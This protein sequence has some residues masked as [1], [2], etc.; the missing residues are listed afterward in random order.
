MIDEKDNPSEDA[1]AAAA[2]PPLSEVEQLKAKAD[3]YLDL[4]R[5]AKADFINYQDRVRRDRQEWNRQAIEKFVTELLPALDGF[6][7]AK[8]DDP[9]LL[10]AVRMLEKEFLRT[11]AKFQIV[12][13]ET[14]GK[15]FDPQ[16]H[17][18]VAMEP[19]GTAVEE[20]RR[21]WLIEGRVLRPAGV[22]LVKP[23][24][25]SS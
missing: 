25:P 15:P 1:D 7:L 5:R 22:R 2:T 3:E 20:V 10:E 9:K 6:S 14:A 8:F 13:I 16:Y 19:G 23:A 24:G 11:L 4:A 17:D 18:A 21:G 12:P